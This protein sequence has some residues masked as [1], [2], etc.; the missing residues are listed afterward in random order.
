[1]EKYSPEKPKIMADIQKANDR[2]HNELENTT[3]ELQDMR[4]DFEAMLKHDEE[5]LEKQ[6]KLLKMLLDEEEDVDKMLSET[7]ELNEKYDTL[8]ATVA[9]MKKNV[10]ES[11]TETKQIEQDVAYLDNKTKGMEEY[12]QKVA[13]RIDTLH[14]K[15]KEHEDL[16]VDVVDVADVGVKAD[17]EKTVTLAK[18]IKNSQ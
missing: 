12:V 9:N 4:I 17:L 11:E 13:K 5:L 6:H 16:K 8:E 2:F 14:D 15:S 7:K 1:M 18:Q 3:S 10:E